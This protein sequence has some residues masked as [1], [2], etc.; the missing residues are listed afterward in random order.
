MSSALIDGHGVVLALLYEYEG[1]VGGDGMIP[2]ESP[3]PPLGI[4]SGAGFIVQRSYLYPSGRLRSA[5]RGGGVDVSSGKGD[6][7]PRVGVVAPSLST[8]ATPSVAVAA[9]PI[10]PPAFSSPSSPT[11]TVSVADALNF[12]AALLSRSDA[13]IETTSDV[14]PPRRRR[15]RRILPPLNSS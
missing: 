1:R 5:G 9:S 6:S 10:S 3:S 4:E 15:T 12:S 2:K 14:S 11:V 7:N 13:S 8:T